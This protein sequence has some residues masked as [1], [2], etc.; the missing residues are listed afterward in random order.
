M[1]FTNAA[2]LSPGD[3][4]SAPGG[5][6]LRVLRIQRYGAYQQARNLTIAHLHTYFVEAGA[7]PI[8]VHNCGGAVR[9]DVI[10]E[11]MST[12][13]SNADIVPHK[14][15]SS[16]IGQNAITIEDVMATGHSFVG[17]GARDVSKGR[18][19]FRS[20]DGSRGFRVDPASLA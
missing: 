18:G 14:R 19:V 11:T 17:E 1:G 5:K 10:D 15:Q 12:A 9:D 3:R 20:A 16:I 4:L 6:T 13:E 8:L 2:D 7:T